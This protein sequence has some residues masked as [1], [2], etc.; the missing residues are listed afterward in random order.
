MSIKEIAGNIFRLLKPEAI[1][2]RDELL[3][4]L[5]EIA[6]DQAVKASHE[7]Q[8]D[9]EIQITRNKYA[10]KIASLEAGI[11]HDTKRVHAWAKQN[12]EKEFGKKQTLIIAGHELKFH[13]SAGGVKPIGELTEDEIVENLINMEGP[14]GAE[15]RAMFLRVSA[16]LDKVAVKREF[17]C[18]EDQPERRTFVEQCG[19]TVKSKESFKLVTAR[20][21]I[22]DNV[23]SIPAQEV[24]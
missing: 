4:V 20:V 22:T 2:S 15:A 24:A 17:D 7:L 14:E 3:E 1:T 9:A 19:L 16:E 18:G 13:S 8:M 5:T 10:K 6:T 11:N 12:R 23:E 21:E